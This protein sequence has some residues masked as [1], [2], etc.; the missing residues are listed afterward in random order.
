MET[1]VRYVLLDANVIAGYYFPQTLQ[2]CPV[3]AKRIKV[4]IDS[5]KKGN[6]HDIKLLAPNICVAEAFTVMSKRAITQW[7]DKPKKEISGS[8]DLRTYKKKRKEFADDIHHSNVIESV[9]LQRYHV[10]AKHFISPVDHKTVL[11]D[12]SGKPLPELGGTDQLIGGMGIWLSRF[13]GKERFVILTTDYRLAKILKKAKNLN[14]ER[15]RKLGLYEIAK[16]I[17]MNWWGPDVYPNIIDIE[18]DSDNDL[19]KFFGIWSLLTKKPRPIRK[20]KPTSKDINCLL[21]LYRK[22]GIAR[23]KLP[24]TSHMSQLRDSFVKA[25]GLPFSEGEI[26]NLLISRLKKGGG[27]LRKIKT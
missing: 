22:I 15:A 12:H 4:I 27:G 14:T 3:A 11:K 25:T 5:V 21:E 24:Y 17:E 13:L 7:A 9:E 16:E 6:C 19:R 2:N 8:I 1:P 23:D 20:R 18:R 10:L 26:W